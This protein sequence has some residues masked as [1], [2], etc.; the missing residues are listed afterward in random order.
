MTFSKQNYWTLGWLYYGKLNQNSELPPRTLEYKTV[1]LAHIP[2]RS[3]LLCFTWL[4]GESNV[5][6]YCYGH[7]AALKRR[8][9]TLGMWGHPLDTWNINGE[10]FVER[11]SPVKASTTKQMYMHYSKA[12]LCNSNSKTASVHASGISLF[13][14]FYLRPQ[15]ISSTSTSESINVNSK[16]ASLNER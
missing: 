9:H 6:C 15:V 10:W 5:P 13:S 11:R 4:S 1:R 12:R 7:C 3:P 16:L 2:R 14:V 8:Q